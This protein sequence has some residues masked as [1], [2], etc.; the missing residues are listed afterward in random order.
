MWGI[1]YELEAKLYACGIFTAWDFITKI[2]Q[3]RARRIHNIE[4]ERTWCEL[5]GTRCYHVD[6]IQPDKLT[7]ITSRSLPHTVKDKDSLKQALS[8]YA[9][10][11]AADLRKQKTYAKTIAIF[12]E[13]NR[14]RT[15]QPQY[16]PYLEIELPFPANT[17]LTLVKHA[18][19]G[20]DEIY[21]N[22]FE[23]KKVGI[24][25]TKTTKTVQTDLYTPIDKELKQA[26]ISP[27]EDFYAHGFD[28]KRCSL[29]VMGYGDRKK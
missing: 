16:R 5:Q 12:L 14:F 21:L 26:K 17:T 8:T 29:A 4:L 27:V 1:G 11:S 23:Y 6:P 24:Q 15:N 2:S 3:T 18:L 10:I 7:L 13:T 19:K 25:I 9:A 28:R 20:L 22:G